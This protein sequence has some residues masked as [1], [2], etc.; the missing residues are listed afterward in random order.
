MKINGGPALTGLRHLAARAQEARKPAEPKSVSSAATETPPT[1]KNLPPATAAVQPESKADH[2][3]GLG[4][5]IERL[6]LNAL[7]SPEATGLQHALERLQ[8]NP[9][10]GGTVDTQ[11]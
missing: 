9:K 1:G 7:K 3:T 6:Q 11:V 2:A 5:A 8:S 4:R 10:S